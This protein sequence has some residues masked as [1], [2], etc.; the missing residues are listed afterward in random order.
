MVSCF[1]ASSSAEKDLFDPILP[2]PLK[3][4]TDDVLNEWYPKHNNKFNEEPFGHDVSNPFDFPY[5]KDLNPRPC[6]QR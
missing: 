5:I 2:V 6:L 1:N 3:S 4:L